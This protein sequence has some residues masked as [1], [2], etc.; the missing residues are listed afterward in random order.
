[1]KKL[2][3]WACPLGAVLIMFCV[4]PVQAMSAGDMKPGGAVTAE[5]APL[6]LS[7][8]VQDG[9]RVVQVTASQYKFIPDPIVVKQGDKVR[10]V[11]TSADVAHGFYVREFN[12]NVAVSSG[13]TRSGDFVADKKGTFDVICSVYC[14]PGHV[15]MRGKL[16]VE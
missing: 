6:S 7:G 12:F 11:L 4:G 8:S 5:H 14:G 1:M 2:L 3:L 13:E 9:V 10:I 15:H 16:I